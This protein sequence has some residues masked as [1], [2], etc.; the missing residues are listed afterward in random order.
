MK[1]H[2]L[3]EVLIKLKLLKFLNL[4]FSFKIN[5]KRFKFPIINLIGFQNL[6]E[7]KKGRETHLDKI[8][9]EIFL[10]KTG[11]FIDVGVNIGQTLFKVKSID[12]SRDYFGFDP[13]PSCCFY[14]KKIIKINS[15]ENSHIIPVGL[16][17]SLAILKLFTKYGDD[18]PHA[19]VIDGYREKSFYNAEQ[20]TLLCEGDF[21]LKE[22]KIN[23]ISIIKIDVEGAELEVIEGLK[24]SIVQYK[25]F[26]ICEILAIKDKDE[27]AHHKKNRVN[28]LEKILKNENYLIGR[29]YKNNKIVI[30]DEID[31]YSKPVE[32]TF[33]YLF[34][35]QAMNKFFELFL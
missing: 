26:I 31:L 13:S 1:N 17:N 16:Y 35:P 9:A 3:A 22:L 32:S 30:L 29:I 24:N 7:L 23:S 11:A 8:I 33:D 18:D 27:M 34:V 15:F 21:L 25:P 19:S 2:L 28:R 5:G 12:L 10:K 20:Y 14:V 6:R 4:V